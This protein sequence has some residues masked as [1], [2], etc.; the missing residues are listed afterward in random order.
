MNCFDI[1]SDQD[2]EYRVSVVQLSHDN[3]FI[4]IPEV[5]FL[6]YRRKRVKPQIRS[7]IWQTTNGRC[8]LCKTILASDWEVEHVVA[9]SAD[10]ETSDVMGNMLPA[11][12]SCNRF[13]SNKRLS[14]CIERD[15][16]YGARSI[17]YLFFLPNISLYLI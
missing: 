1:A 10:P 17:S 8:Y 13:K 6:R 16:S 12:R 5:E 11:C 3:E 15:L 4:E 9:F 2:E 7:F 14:K